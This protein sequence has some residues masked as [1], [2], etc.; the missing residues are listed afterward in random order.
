MKIAEKGWIDEETISERIKDDNLK[1][2][3]SFNRDVVLT[4]VSQLSQ[5]DKLAL[6]KHINFDNKDAVQERKHST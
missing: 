3:P 2:I 1:M 5:F 4:Q 6:L